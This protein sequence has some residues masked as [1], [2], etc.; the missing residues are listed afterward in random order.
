MNFN[1]VFIGGNLT[2]DPEMRTSA[3]GTVFVKFGIAINEYA[4][5]D[6]PQRTTYVDVTAFG[7]RAEAVHKHFSQGDPIFIAGRLDFSVWADSSGAKRSKLSVVLDDFQ[8]CGGD[9]ATPTES[10]A[11]GSSEVPF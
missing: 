10:T 1:R 3:G 2:R 7:K 11:S 8:F 9:R 5:K 4:G 6:K